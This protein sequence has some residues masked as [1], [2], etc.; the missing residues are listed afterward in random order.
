VV[1]ALALGHLFGIPPLA[2]LRFNFASCLWGLL[3]TAPLVLVL[4]WILGQPAG[5]LQQLVDFV[6]DHL[7]PIVAARGVM[8]L[9]L[10]AMCAGL[11]EELLFRGVVQAGLS[12]LMPGGAALLVAS[13]LFGLAHCVTSTYAVVAGLMG[14]Y[15]GALYL[16]QGS[17]VAPVIAHTL[18]DFVA[19]LII[20]GRY[21][22]SQRAGPVE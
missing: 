4:A 6:V 19:L 17:L 22:S 14:M 16:L 2:Q 13:L 11:G 9:G 8:S 7:G 3:A 12:K 20:A 15:L 10:L 5:R 1:L 18:Y 21:R